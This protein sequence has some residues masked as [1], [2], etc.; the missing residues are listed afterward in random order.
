MVDPNWW[1][2][3]FND[4]Y[5]KTDARSVCDDDITKLEV[6]IFCDMLDL[7]KEDRI[8]D[9]CCGH[10]RHSIEL[11]KRG[12]KNIT[13][14]DYSDHLLKIAKTNSKKLG[15][16]INI[17]QGNAVDTKIKASS[18]DHVLLLGNS[19]GYMID[20]NADLLILK[21]I[22]RLLCTQG[23]ILLDLSN[24]TNIKDLKPNI[25]YE[26]GQDIVVCRQRECHT[27]KIHTREMVISKKNGLIRDQTYAIKLY[28]PLSLKALVE[29]AGFVNIKNRLDISCHKDEKDYGFMNNRMIFVARKP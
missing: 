9:L 28:E 24:A 23:L 3:L 12:Y 5:L 18:F 25:W 8:L 2:T 19:L 14:F 21:E 1:K 15:F 7:K 13:L 29:K 16:K 22:Y 10:G 17:V 11:C 20:S 6:D 4:V 26:I 27:K